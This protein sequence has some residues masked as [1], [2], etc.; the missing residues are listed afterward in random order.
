[1]NTTLAR[2]AVAVAACA[3]AA[4]TGAVAIAPQASAD[5]P[6]LTVAYPAS[7]STFVA[8]PKSTIALGPSTLTAALNADGTFG[9]SLPLP[10]AKANFKVIGLV[11]VSATVSFIPVGQLSGVLDGT[12]VSASATYTLKLTNVTLGGLPGLVGSRCQTTSPVSIPV[13]TPA[14]QNFDILKGG[15]VSG[16]YK[17]GNFSH[18]GLTTGLV[19]LLVPGSGNTVSFTLGAGQVVT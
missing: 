5:A 9:G 4:L 16:S 11:P 17:I 3:A 8:K 12:T 13:S 15:T 1:M 10:P 18:C 7:G 14:G 19:N 6:V 2:R